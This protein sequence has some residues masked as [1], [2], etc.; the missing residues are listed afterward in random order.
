MSTTKL[1]ALVIIA[2]FAI[3]SVHAALLQVN[4]GRPT[5]P[6]EPGFTKWTTNDNT[7]PGATTISGI[8]LSV[9]VSVS[10]SGG[11]TA[12]RSLD[13]SDSLY[14]GTLDN[15][16]D[17]WWGARAGTIGQPG[18][19]Q[20]SIIIDGADL[21][22]GTFEFTSWHFDHDNQTGPMNIEYSVDGG[23]G[24]TTVFSNFDIVDGDT[25]LFVGAPNPALFLFTSNGTDDVWIR[26]TNSDPGGGDGSTNFVV[27]NGFQLIE[28]P[29]PSTMLMAGLGLTGVCFRRR[30]R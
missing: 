28:I 13:R 5:T 25:D 4:V 27:V 6:T 19:A 16:T 12:L 26:F 17:N 9:N 18:G 14:T 1:S 15:L 23:T 11:G 22:A 2:V 24:F 21:G 8:G 7:A 20:F 29:E 30:R 3:S 10:D